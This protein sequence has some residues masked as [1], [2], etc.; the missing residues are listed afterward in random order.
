MKNLF[1]VVTIIVVVALTTVTAIAQ[2][3]MTPAEKTSA[4]AATT[5]ISAL[6]PTTGIVFQPSVSTGKVKAVE[7]LG[8]GGQN[9]TPPVGIVKK[10]VIDPVLDAG[11][12]DGGQP[13]GGVAGTKDEQ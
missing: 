6:K 1:F 2:H 10:S 9:T 11:K 3:A 13:S 7:L 12:P 8:G 4:D 5:A